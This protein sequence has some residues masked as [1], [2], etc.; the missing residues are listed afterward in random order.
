MPEFPGLAAQAYPPLTGFTGPGGS[1]TIAQGFPVAA[2]SACTPEQVPLLAPQPPLQGGDMR[3]RN[4]YMHEN[5][6]A[7]EPLLAPPAT[8]PP[9][10]AD[11]PQV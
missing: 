5:T 8:A 4:P 6:D 1:G 2:S 10:E 7:V 3:M 11:L 9:A